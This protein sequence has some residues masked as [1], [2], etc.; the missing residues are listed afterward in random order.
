MIMF[1]KSKDDTVP[2]IG[3]ESD[4][5]QGSYGN[6][7]PAFLAS[8]EVGALFA[9]AQVV[10]YWIQRSRRSSKAHIDTRNKQLTFHPPGF[11]RLLRVFA[12]IFSGTC[13]Y[14]LGVLIPLNYAKHESVPGV[15]GMDVLS[16]LNVPRSAPQRFWGHFSIAFCSILYTYYVLW[17]EVDK[18]VTHHVQ[19]G[20]NQGK[21][22]FIVTGMP[23][24]DYNTLVRQALYRYLSQETKYTEIVDDGFLDFKENRL[25][26]VIDNIEKLSLKALRSG[27]KWNYQREKMQS[28][29]RITD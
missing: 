7:L 19:N 1:Q 16:C 29:L 23:N 11:Y 20:S 26:D 18:F 15:T 17:D 24:S 14:T 27:S 28:V 9:I 8:I 10:A 3:L 6:S 5:A 13:T 4:K 25:G 21:W 2:G 22:T 12:R